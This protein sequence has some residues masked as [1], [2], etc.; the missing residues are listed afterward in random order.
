MHR[1]WVNRII[2]SH[3]WVMGP[4]VM[5]KSIH[6]N[7]KHPSIYKEKFN[8][9]TKHQGRDQRLSK[10]QVHLL[11]IKLSLFLHNT[12]IDHRCKLK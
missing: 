12:Y 4:T 7:V 11:Q 5:I 6:T 8:W 9:Q 1:N 10:I 3:P 2:T